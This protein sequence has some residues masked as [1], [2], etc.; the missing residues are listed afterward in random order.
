MYVLI[1]LHGQY[2]SNSDYIN[3]QF[4][5]VIFPNAPNGSWINY[6]S[7]DKPIKKSVEYITTYLM[8][9]LKLYVNIIGDSKKILLGGSSQGAALAMHIYALYSSKY[10]E[11]GGFIGCRSEK[12]YD[13]TNVS[14]LKSCISP[15][16]F[17][18][19]AKDYWDEGDNEQTTIKKCK[20][21]YVQFLKK[22]NTNLNIHLEMIKNA[23]HNNMGNREYE[24]IQK[25]LQKF[26]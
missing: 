11:L 15:I 19:G 20:L 17:F 1:F 4:K 22:Q 23:N 6:D 3:Y 26:Y 18:C 12:L 10:S 13:F 25:F 24:F 14:N 2:A 8:S 5:N 16:Y 21:N 7:N 9:L